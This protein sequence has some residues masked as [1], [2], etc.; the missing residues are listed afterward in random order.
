VE[1]N[2]EKEFVCPLCGK[3]EGFG[4]NWVQDK[5]NNSYL[6][7]CYACE[8]VFETPHKIELVNE[9]IEIV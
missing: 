7:E 1:E 6:H 9:Q 5:V 8:N 2:K 3:C 4:F